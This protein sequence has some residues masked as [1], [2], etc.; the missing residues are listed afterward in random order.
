M[1][2][3]D[4][5][6]ALAEEFVFCGL[7]SRVKGDCRIRIAVFEQTVYLIDFA[8]GAV[9]RHKPQRI[10]RA[11]DD[12]TLVSR[13]EAFALIVDVTENSGVAYRLPFVTPADFFR[14][15]H[16]HEVYHV[17]QL[18]AA[19][20][21]IFYGKVME[22][23]VGGEIDALFAGKYPHYVTPDFFGVLVFAEFIVVFAHLRQLFDRGDGDNDAAGQFLADD[24][25]GDE[26]ETRHDAGLQ[27][28]EFDGGRFV[29]E[30]ARH[31][32]ERDFQIVGVVGKLR[33]FAGERELHRVG[34]ALQGEDFVERFM[35]FAHLFDAAEIVLDGGV[36]GFHLVGA[37]AVE[38]P[39]EL[40]ARRQ[41]Y[42][43]RQQLPLVDQR[44]QAG[45]EVGRIRRQRR[46]HGVH[47]FDVGELA[48]PCLGA[49]LG[50]L[51]QEILSDGRPQRTQ[52]LLVV[53]DGLVIFAE[54]G[55]AARYRREGLGVAEL[56]E[57]FA[58]LFERVEARADYLLQ[59]LAALLFGC[60]IVAVGA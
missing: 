40:D 38:Y 33:R 9:E 23:A 48:G 14:R 56:A 51:E 30:G 18:S 37:V 10:R 13:G 35:F 44:R 58:A 2:Q 42:A 46:G 45:V 22:Y 27:R 8:A 59:P 57:V 41:Q 24:D 52:I 3:V 17:R 53:G 16:T 43:L 36:F 47:L 55:I 4:R 39:V 11:F 1:Y 25:R 50:V 60:G 19:D 5:L 20:V 15:R 32:V 29:V 12:A 31:V 6:L 26:V 54:H 7:A 21:E 34:L 49:F 28:H